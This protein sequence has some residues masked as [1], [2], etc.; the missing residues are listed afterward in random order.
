[1]PPSP[2]PGYS[3]ADY[4]APDVPDYVIVELRY[5]SQVAAPP[6]AAVFVA[7]EAAAPTRDALNQVLEDFSVKRVGPHFDLKKKV[8]TRRTA[9]AVP[10]PAM[11]APDAEFALAGFVDVVLN[12]PKQCGRLID[13]L[14]QAQGVW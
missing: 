13:R 8:F 5:D 10:V 4:R 7:Q 11:A 14:K 12:D 6:G 9:S 2:S 3:S 1:M